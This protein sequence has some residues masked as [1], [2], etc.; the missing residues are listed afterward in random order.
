MNLIFTGFQLNKSYTFI[1]K[2]YTYSW[3]LL[4]K[5]NPASS[6]DYKLQVDLIVYNETQRE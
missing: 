1:N 3:G 4:S 6:I 2:S 5:L